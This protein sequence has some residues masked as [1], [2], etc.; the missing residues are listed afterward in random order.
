MV[1]TP[2]TITEY[3]KVL[4]KSPE[5]VILKLAKQLKAA[6]LYKGTPTGKINNSF[7]DAVVKADEKRVQL[8]AIKGEIDRTDFITQLAL[9]GTGTGTGAGGPSTTRAR[10]ITSKTKGASTLDAIGQELLGRQLTDAEKAKYLKM[11][12]AEE[13]KAS[14]DTVTKYS[15]AGDMSTTTTGLDKEQFLIEKISGTDEAKANKVLDAYTTVV[16]MLGGLR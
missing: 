7:I 13:V 1:D 3:L 2:L 16:N 12:N 9:Q 4:D 10:S 6:G 14:S 15:A 8:V 11:L 5:S